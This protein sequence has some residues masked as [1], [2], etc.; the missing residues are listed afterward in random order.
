MTRRL[1]DPRRLRS[2][3]ADYPAALGPWWPEPPDLAVCGD[4]ALLRLP[5]TALLCSIAAAPGA[6]LAAH[7]LARGLR[8]AGVATVGGFQSPVERE[9]LRPLLQGRQPVVVAAAR[10]LQGMRVPA[11]WA[12]ALEQGRLVVVSIA[13]RRRADAVS[14]AERNRLVAALA[15]R[16]VVMHATPGGRLARVTLEA[17]GRGRPVHCLDLPEN[18]DLRLAGARAAEVGSMLAELAMAARFPVA[19]GIR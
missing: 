4:V 19:S 5:L 2:G 16:V 11:D 15:T 9:C 14:A 8:G 7:D 18:D 17:I 6:V 1:A 10:D 12:G 3:E 13:R